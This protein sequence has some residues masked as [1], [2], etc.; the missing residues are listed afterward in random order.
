MIRPLRVLCLEDLE[1]DYELVLHALSLPD[2]TISSVRVETENEYINQLKQFDPHIIIADNKLPSYDGLSALEAARRLRPDIPFIFFSG[3]LGEDAAIEALKRGATD[4][5]LKQKQIHLRPAVERAIREWEETQKLKGAEKKLRDSE[6]LYHSLVENLPQNV[7]RSDVSGRFTFVNSQFCRFMGKPAEQIIGLTFSDLCPTAIAH[8]FVRNDRK[9]IESDSILESV[10]ELSSSEREGRFIKL[11]RSPLHDDHHQNIGL[12]GIFWDITKHKLAET[13]IRNLNQL[14]HSIRRINGL[15]VRE[16][17]PD[18]LL[19]DACRILVQTRGYELVWIGYVNAE[20]MR[21]FPAVWAGRKGADY[22]N[23]ISITWDESPY[24]RGPIGNAIRNLAPSVI[25]NITTDPAFAPWRDAAIECGYGSV[26]A[27]PLLRGK[28]ALGAM[29]VYFD[30]PEAFDSEEIDLLGELA[31]DLS[32]ALQSIANEEQRKQA[33]E[34]LIIQGRTLIESEMRYRDLFE[35]ANEIIYTLDLKGRFTSLNK[36]GRQTIG[37]DSEQ[38]MGQNI[39]KFVAPEYMFDMQEILHRT[40][41]GE[42]LPPAELV[43]INQGGLR[44]TIEVSNRLIMLD[45]KPVGVQGIA[46]DLTERNLLQRQLLQAQKMEAVG[47]LAGGVAHDFNNLLTIIIGNSDLLMESVPES[48]QAYDDIDQIR[49]AGLRAADLTSKL[50]AFSRM[51]IL[52]PRVLN[53]NVLIHES[54][55]LLGRLIGEDIELIVRADPGLGCIKADATQME[56][57]IM[58][59]AVNAKD[60]MAK[61]GKFTIETANVELDENF[62]TRHPGSHRGRFIMMSAADTGTG[63]DMETKSHI[64][65]PFFTTKEEGKGTGLGLAMVYGIVKQ[66]GGYIT[67]ESE[68]GCGATFMIYL[69]QVD[70]DPMTEISQECGKSDGIE[71][72]LLVEDMDEVRALAQRALRKR[73]Y[74]V[75]EASDGLSALR[76]AEQYLSPI[77]LLITDLIM[78]GGINGRELADRLQ[79]AHSG[80]KVLLIS[81]YS[82]GI[83]VNIVDPKVGILVKPFTGATL[84]A[85]AREI[86]QSS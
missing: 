45:E 21:V 17:D 44:I 4:Y 33:E 57:I 35:N 84:A 27:F 32:F 5:V 20:S 19:N 8:Q 15:M 54:S 79:I 60:A 75:L 76:I 67:V 68:P 62:V 12:Q 69:P 29:A 16:R 23:N 73:G 9:V 85:K 51:Q 34:K 49:K 43:I 61:G 52:Q 70:E 48:E 56:Q 22:L 24:G 11:I 14:L 66:S 65:E 82:S 3:T 78:P 64:F 1:A 40:I 81:G 28:Q 72:I 37:F 36:I 38:I 25:N 31:V 55:K 50:L 41:S 2:F 80:I 6:A 47:R 59:M 18:K 58:N 83:D 46:R 13:R 7:Y 26:A 77:H 74:T 10:E 63:M 42:S 39:D 53:L 30:R 86:L 71:T